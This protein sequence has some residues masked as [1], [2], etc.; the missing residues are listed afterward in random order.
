MLIVYDDAIRHASE[1]VTFAQQYSNWYVPG[2]SPPPHE[3]PQ[4]CGFFEP[5]FTVTFSWTYDVPGQKIYRQLAIRRPN[6]LPHH[7]SADT[8]ASWFGFTGGRLDGW[9]IT[10]P[11]QDWVRQEMKIHQS[12]I[13]SQEIPYVEYS[14]FVPRVAQ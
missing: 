11:G 14:R 12:V 9:E 1:M 7:R 6:K 13:L 8:M 10:A 2:H 4:L 5:C 3:I